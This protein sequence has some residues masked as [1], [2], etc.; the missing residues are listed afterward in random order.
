MNILKSFADAET[1]PFFFNGD[2]FGTAIPHASCPLCCSA[3]N[4]SINM[5]ITLI[6]LWLKIPTTP[7]FSLTIF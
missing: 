7:Q 3:R 1:K 2:L 6:P 5:G 4:E